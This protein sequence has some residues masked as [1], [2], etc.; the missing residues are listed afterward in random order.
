MG[1]D[2]MKATV[3]LKVLGAEKY[4]RLRCLLSPEKSEDKAFDEL[5]LTLK[6]LFGSIKSLFRRRHDILNLRASPETKAEEILS[7]CSLKGMNSSWGI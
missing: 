7:M 4:S 1:T 3:L 2:S 5:L 6:T